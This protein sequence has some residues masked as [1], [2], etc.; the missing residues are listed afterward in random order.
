[1]TRLTDQG[2]DAAAK[3]LDEYRQH[4]GAN[5]APEAAH[6]WLREQV[7][8]GKIRVYLA[9]AAEGICT[10]AIVP[11]ALTLRTVWLIRD[12]YV[13]PGSRRRG[14][15]RALL[16]AVEEEAR[17]DGAHR[18]SLQTETTNVRAIE[19]YADCG[20]TPLSD[21]TVMDEVLRAGGPS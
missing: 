16:A 21:V 12:L 8:A 15:A 20:F 10:V 5:P 17:A 6:A 13:R 11:A 19:L 9:G 18:L 14:L 2:W 3:V 1:V 4:Y 7:E